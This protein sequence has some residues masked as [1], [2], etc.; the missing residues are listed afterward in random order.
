[1][2]KH[3]TCVCEI[4]KELINITYILKESHHLLEEFHL[5]AYFL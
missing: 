3:I 1:M 2:I 5:W 4:L